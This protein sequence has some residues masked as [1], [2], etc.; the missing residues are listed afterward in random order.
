MRSINTV[1]EKEC[2]DFV[3]RTIL[4]ASFASPSLVASCGCSSSV[5]QGMRTCESCLPQTNK[6][7]TD[8]AESCSKAGFHP[9]LDAPSKTVDLG[10]FRDTVTTAISSSHPASSPEGVAGQ[11]VMRETLR[12]QREVM[13]V[14]LPFDDVGSRVRLRSPFGEGGWGIGRMVRGWMGWRNDE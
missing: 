11:Y 5:L 3:E 8:W 6:Y 2:E 7:T 9:V 14:R 13:M 12:N 4:C 10:G 1:C